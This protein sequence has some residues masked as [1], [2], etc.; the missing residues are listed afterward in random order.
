[1]RQ[2]IQTHYIGPRNVRGSRVKAKASGGLSLTLEWD[3]ALDMTENHR[4]AA[5]ALARKLNWPGRWYVGGAVG[6]GCVFVQD[7]GGP[8]GFT[9]F[10]QPREAAAQAVRELRAEAPESS[11]GIASAL[12]AEARRLGFALLNIDP[13]SDEARS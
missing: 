3:D 6:G 8:E 12:D 2:S 7:D 10:P 9:I 1:V 11:G 4:T 5:M 13:D